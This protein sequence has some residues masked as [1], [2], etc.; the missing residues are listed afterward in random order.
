[1]YNRKFIIL[2]ATVL[3]TAS[4]AL[5]VSFTM[6]PEPK[7]VADKTAD[8]EPSLLVIVTNLGEIPDYFF[9]KLESQSPQLYLF[10]REMFHLV[11][12]CLLIGISYLF[13]RYD[14]PHAPLVF[15]LPLVGW[16]TYQEVWLHPIIYSQKWWNGLLDWGVW[17]V[18]FFVYM[19]LLDSNDSNR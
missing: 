12:T 17:I 18:P 19:L 4:L 9:P 16:I 8:V 13:Y 11:A 2:V 5:L 15:F 10:M 7:M 14:N 1:M 6:P 3:T